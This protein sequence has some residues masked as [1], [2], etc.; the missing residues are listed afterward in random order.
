VAAVGFLPVRWVDIAAWS[1]LYRIRLKPW[2][3]DVI[4]AIDDE[5]LDVMS[6]KTVKAEDLQGDAVDA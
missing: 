6:R 3:L 1:T 5:W 2:E 4:T